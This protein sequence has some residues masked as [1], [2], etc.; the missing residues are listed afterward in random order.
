MVERNV[1]QVEHRERGVVVRDVARE[2]LV[3]CSLAVSV[4]P[5]LDYKLSFGDPNGSDH[6]RTGVG[7]KPHVT[8]PEQSSAG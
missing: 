4:R 6:S 5:K 7:R 8:G 1:V 3:I 2:K